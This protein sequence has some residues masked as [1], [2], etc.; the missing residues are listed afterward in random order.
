MIKLISLLLFIYISVLISLTNGRTC[1]IC[2][3]ESN[4]A[5]ADPFDSSNASFIQLSGYIYCQKN[6]YSN[7]L[8][9]RFGGSTCSISD[10]RGITT[11]YCCSNLD[12]CNYDDHQLTC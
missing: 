10:I 6:V 7:G 12:S 5:C 11:V 3:S 4:P 8:I 1:I 2:S 9:T